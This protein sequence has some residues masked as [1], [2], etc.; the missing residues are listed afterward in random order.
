MALRLTE[1][2]R[3]VRAEQL[4]AQREIAS[5]LRGACVSSNPPVSQREIAI[6][7]GIHE[8]TFSKYLNGSRV[9]PEGAADLEAKVFEALHAIRERQGVAA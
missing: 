2:E 9:W 4:R 3:L 8:T 1:G 6:D 7:L 5:R